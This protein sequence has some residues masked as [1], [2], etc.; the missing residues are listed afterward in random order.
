MGSV[1]MINPVSILSNVITLRASQS[2]EYEEIQ[3]GSVSKSITKKIK[4]SPKPVVI[5]T[6][7]ANEI[8]LLISH[9]DFLQYKLTNID[10]LCIAQLWKKHLNS[11]GS[12]TSWSDLCAEIGMNILDTN[13]CL[14]YIISLLERRIISFD[15][16]V[17][18]DYHINPIILLSAE[19]VLHSELILK[20]LGR[21][22]PQELNRLIAVDWEK[23][24]D[25]MYDFKLC[26]ETM[27]NCFGE[28]DTSYRRKGKTLQPDVFY[29][30]LRPLLDRLSGAKKGLAITKLID[31][32][33][34]T[35]TEICI[36]LLVLYVQLTQ[37]NNISDRELLQIIC[38]NSY[39]HKQITYYLAHNGK[40]LKD[41]LIEIKDITNFV[42]RR[43]LSI[44]E[45][46]IKQLSGECEADGDSQLA[47]Y[48]NHSS[49]LQT[50]KASQT[51]D[52]LIIPDQDKQPL[53][54]ITKQYK[55]Y[56]DSIKAGK[57]DKSKHNPTANN[58]LIV[59][60]YGEPGTGKTYAA[61]ALA[62]SLQKDLVCVNCTELRNKYYSESEKLVKRA[63]RL[64]RKM[65][66][67]LENP[68]VFLINE[69][70]QLIHN[71]STNT[72]D[73]SRTDNAIQNIILEELENFP[74][75]LILTTNLES[76]IDEAYYR[77]FNL[78]AKF[79][80]PDYECRV[81]LW[82]LHLNQVGCSS[83]AIDIEYLAKTY[84]FTGGQIALVVKNS[85][86]ET[87][88]KSIKKHCISMNTIIKYADL[89]QP[90]ISHKQRKS[91]GF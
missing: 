13:V 78:K 28:I 30:C 61:G 70:D 51:L 44:Q 1:Q 48:I 88:T 53:Y 17:T 49:V 66:L 34:L 76:N 11:T 64:M 60:F 16:N 14:E 68:P 47:K 36:L 3:P 71:R 58:G 24:S 40:L 80:P 27:F 33:Q 6:D 43:E 55:L 59:F 84:P 5:N 19:Y 90:W 32:N 52:E 87:G 39:E 62:N 91:V 20:I 72:N 23:D 50:V 67:D 69:A 4:A 10:V 15:E 77:R 7:L 29:K 57:S 21:N 31:E 22:I 8:S 73:C 26:M 79:S 89:E 45:D 63:F 46:L 86:L 65:S 41:G 42:N 83:K 2:G 38:R 54:A 74:G 82:Q 9:P 81:K 18:S 37:D 25:F 56:A 75:I 85:I 35:E 12:S